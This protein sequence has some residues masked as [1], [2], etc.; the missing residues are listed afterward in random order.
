VSRGGRRRV[1]WTAT[2]RP[3]PVWCVL[4]RAFVLET[5]PPDGEDGASI[6]L[7]FVHDRHAS[8]LNP[9]TSRAY[10]PFG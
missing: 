6:G 2:R 8:K 1:L 3:P 4:R 10:Q 7:A 5:P 9:V